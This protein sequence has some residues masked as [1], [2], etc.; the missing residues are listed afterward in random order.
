MTKIEKLKQKLEENKK[1]LA[2]VRTLVKENEI[3]VLLDSWLYAD[4]HE[5]E[6]IELFYDVE[7]DKIT[8]ENTPKMQ[9]VVNGDEI[10]RPDIHLIKKIIEEV[11]EG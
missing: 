10:R 7:K 3:T 1:E 9:N 8:Y 11:N 5:Y 4:F 6:C 2:Y